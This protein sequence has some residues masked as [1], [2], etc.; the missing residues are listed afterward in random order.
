[1]RIVTDCAADLPK[2]E[3]ELLSIVQAM[4]HISLPDRQVT[5]AEVDI[6]EF[7]DLLEAS[8]PAI[9]TTSQPSVGEFVQIYEQYAER[10]PDVLSLHISSGLSGTFASAAMARDQVKDRVNVEV[11]DTMTLSGGERFQVLLA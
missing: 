6:D 7:Y 8:F 10:D 3:V 9:P 5:S 1:M 2:A 4:L 11:I